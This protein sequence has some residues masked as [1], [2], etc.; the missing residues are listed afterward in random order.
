MFWAIFLPTFGI[1]TFSLLYLLSKR[2]IDNHPTANPQEVFSDKELA[3]VSYH[4]IDMLKA[5]P[6]RP[7]HKNYAVIGGSGYLGT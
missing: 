5:I 1:I 6:S 4:D 2:L 7:T 3:D